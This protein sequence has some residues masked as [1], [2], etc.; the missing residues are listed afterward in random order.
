MKN[1]NSPALAI[2]VALTIAAQSAMAALPASVATTVTA[3]QDDGQD[4]FDLV[5]PVIA[6]FVGLVVVVKLF[7]RFSNKL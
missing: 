1:I 6:T 3:I 2:A 7:K 4:I 5:F